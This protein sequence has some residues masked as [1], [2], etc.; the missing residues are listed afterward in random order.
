MSLSSFCSF[1]AERQLCQAKKAL[2]LFAQGGEEERC[3]GK[4]LICLREKE[5][6][7]FILTTKLTDY[8]LRSETD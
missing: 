8:T 1:I 4:R 5:D 7:F 2:S 3:E 6:E